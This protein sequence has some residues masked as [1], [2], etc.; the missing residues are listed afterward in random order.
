MLKKGKNEG[1]GVKVKYVLLNSYF[2]NTITSI[3]NQHEVINET[4]HIF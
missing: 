2:Q 1:G 4:V 3:W